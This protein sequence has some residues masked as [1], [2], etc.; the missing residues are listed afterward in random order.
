MISPKSK[1]AQTRAIAQQAL[2]PLRGDTERT[3]R[4]IAEIAAAIEIVG[5][6]D[7]LKAA[8]LMRWRDEVRALRYEDWK[9]ANSGD[10]NHAED[11][12]RTVET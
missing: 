2:V 11:R 12:G 5:G 8:E 3:R 10:A 4:R 7:A 9:I 6:L 1:A